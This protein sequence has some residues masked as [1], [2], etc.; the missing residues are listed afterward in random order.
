MTGLTRDLDLLGDDLQRAWR[1]DHGGRRLKR[2]PLRR[3]TVIAVALAALLT[4]AGAAVGSGL[5][6]S[7]H[8]EEQGLLEG[9]ALFKGTHPGCSQLTATSFRCTLDRAPT[10]I[11]FYGPD[12]RRLT[13]AYLGVK[14][15]TVDAQRRVDGGCVATSA[16]GREWRCYLGQEAV[17]RGIIGAGY[18][19]TYLPE[20]PTG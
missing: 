13:N 10:E 18:L 17:T 2:Q 8:D 4:A 20:P 1:A 14:A 15:E 7:S 16:D 11:T 6:K 3:R 9:Y 12:G 19:G 5:L